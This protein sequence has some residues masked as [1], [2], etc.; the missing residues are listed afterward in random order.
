[1]KHKNGIDVESAMK[2][3]P[4]F[5]VSKIRAW[6]IGEYGEVFAG[7]SV[8]EVKDFYRKMIGKADE[9]A[10]AIASEFREI[11]KSKMDSPFKFNEDGE[12]VTTTWRKLAR[13][14]I[15]LPTQISTAYN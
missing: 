14:A 10:E 2:A 9:A 3:K 5:P 8:K 15:S 4:R 11:P 1:M 7:Y 12:T 13:R 6:H